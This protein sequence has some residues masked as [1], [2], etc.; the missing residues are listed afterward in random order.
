M[1][2]GVFW[3]GNGVFWS[4]VCLHMRADREAL[5]TQRLWILELP[6]VSV[7]SSPVCHGRIGLNYEHNNILTPDAIVRYGITA[8]LI[9]Q[10]SKKTALWPLVQKALESMQ[11]NLGPKW[12]KFPIGDSRSVIIK[13]LWRLK[14]LG[15]GAG[16]LPR[17]NSVTNNIRKFG[18]LGMG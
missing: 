14:F 3:H 1:S 15:N 13:D 2:R 9:D 12:H 18:V 10:L 17:A 11:A 8:Y 7:C 5:C 6:H 16:M 4:S